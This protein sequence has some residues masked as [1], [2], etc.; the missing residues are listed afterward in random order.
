MV[1]FEVLLLAIILLNRGGRCRHIAY[2]LPAQDLGVFDIHETVTNGT[3]S[4]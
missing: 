4:E 1:G 3:S 2:N